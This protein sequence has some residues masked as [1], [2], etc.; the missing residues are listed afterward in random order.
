MSDKNRL[1]KHNN[2]VTILF[3]THSADKAVYLADRIILMSSS[4]GKIIW[5]ITVTMPRVP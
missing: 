1:K 2:K 5:D 3:V 4:P